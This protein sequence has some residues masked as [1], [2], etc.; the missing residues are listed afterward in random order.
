MADELLPQMQDDAD[1]QSLRKA[2]VTR[3]WRGLFW[4]ALLTVPLTIARIYLN[5]WLPLYGYHL[6]IA[7]V[8][9]TVA[10]LQTRFTFAWRSGLLFGLLWL[11]G[12]PGIFSFGLAASG[13]WWLVLSCLVASILYSPRF[14]LVISLMTM[15]AL[16]LAGTGFISGVLQPAIPLDR[17]LLLPSAW[18]SLIIVTGVFL[19]LVQLSFAGYARATEGLLLQIKQQRDEIERLSLHD[20][21]TGLPL[22]GLAGDRI[23]MALHA[24]RRSGKRVALLYV[25]LDGFKRV[26]DSLGHDAG[27]TVLRTCAERLRECLRSE[28]TVA[29][30]GGDEF[31]VVVGGITEPHQAGRVAQKLVRAASQPILMEDRQ[32][33]VGASI[34]IALF[35]DDAQD[36]P[37]LRRLADMAM[38]EAKRQGRNRYEYAREPAERSQPSEPAEPI[39]NRSGDRENLLH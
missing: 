36:M 20:P 18:V 15:F 13:V 28:D 3:M 9:A 26:N 33:T 37:G 29:R 11:V 10:H 25:D 31:M 6:F 5:H 17:F 21:L 16:L 24:A 22:A 1:I 8:L 27:D 12:L 39:G 30:V 34:G 23:Q 2:F 14:G 4:V 19:V 32:L 7:V 38:Y 35:P